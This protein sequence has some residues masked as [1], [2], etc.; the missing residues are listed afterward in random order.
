MT[1]RSSAFFVVFGL[2]ALGTTTPAL[3]EDG[4]ASGNT[5][6]AA[7]PAQ[8]SPNQSGTGAVDP[9]ATGSTNLSN[10]NGVIAPPATRDGGLVKPMPE[11]GN[12]PVL[13]PGDV[14]QQAP[15]SQ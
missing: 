10:C 13:R 6:C 4:T 5:G 2:I 8:Q 15:K 14:P 3:S 12:T 9:D 11:H 1:A 7:P